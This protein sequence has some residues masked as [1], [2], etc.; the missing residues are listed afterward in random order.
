MPEPSEIDLALANEPDLARLAKQ[1]G[2]DPALTRT[3]R[4]LLH[5]LKQSIEVTIPDFARFQEALRLVGEGS[6]LL[7]APGGLSLLKELRS[8][9]TVVEAT[10][11]LQ[12]DP[13]RSLIPG[14]EVLRVGSTWRS[15]VAVSVLRKRPAAEGVFREKL[16]ELQR[17]LVAARAPQ[18]AHALAEVSDAATRLMR[19]LDRDDGYLPP[20]LVHLELRVE[21]FLT[22]GV[23]KSAAQ[24]YDELR[25]FAGNLLSLERVSNR[26]RVLEVA[27]A[28]RELEWLHCRYF[29]ARIANHLLRYASTAGVRFWRRRQ[30]VLRLEH[31][32]GE[33]LEG[34]YD[35]SEVIRRLRELETLGCYFSTHVYGV[36]EADGTRMY[37]ARRSAEPAT[38]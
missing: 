5:E 30:A 7:V 17:L 14:I 3:C 1:L 25:A 34:L 36:L 37:S 26:V 38:A 31:I 11:I 15:P 22:S 16:A 33:I 19:D 13:L 12:Q 35:R 6:E 9:R 21:K 24:R 28:Y 10:A 27:A 29:V 2:Y 32:S 23:S 18:R 8:S 20:A 4:S